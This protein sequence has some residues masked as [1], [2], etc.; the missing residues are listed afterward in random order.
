[1]QVRQI[2]EGGGVRSLVDTVRRE[3]LYGFGRGALA[4]Q[5]AGA[6]EHAS[7]EEVICQ[8]GLLGRTCFDDA[9]TLAQVCLQLSPEGSPV[10]CS[11]EG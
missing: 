10:P 6:C 1:M 5:G 2:A 3:K 4:N 8:A 11:E 9:G 7:V